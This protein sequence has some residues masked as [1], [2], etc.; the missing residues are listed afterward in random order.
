MYVYVLIKYLKTE[1]GV[2][3]T[4]LCYFTVDM[5]MLVRGADLHL[6]DCCLNIIRVPLP[7]GLPCCL[8]AL[9]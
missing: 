6:F 7:S 5:K 2:V 8:P 1:I 3:F 9:Q 4:I